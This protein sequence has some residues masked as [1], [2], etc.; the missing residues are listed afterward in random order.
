MAGESA[1]AAVKHGRIQQSIVQWC[2]QEYWNIDQLC[3][4]AKL[5]GCK[6]VEL[7]APTIGRR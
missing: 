4:L 6:S 5:L 2:F 3:S 1:G 7:C